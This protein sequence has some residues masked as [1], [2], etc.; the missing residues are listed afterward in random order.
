MSGR[1]LYVAVRRGVMLIIGAF[2][3]YFGVTKDS[4]AK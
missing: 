3:Q 2:D 1:E 4:P